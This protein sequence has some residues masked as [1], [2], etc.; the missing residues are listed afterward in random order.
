MCKVD[1]SS[2]TK[3]L[4][5]PRDSTLCHRTFYVKKHYNLSEFG[6]LLA[7]SKNVLNGVQRP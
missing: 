3:S 6:Y 7:G 4:A 1:I 2:I 5:G